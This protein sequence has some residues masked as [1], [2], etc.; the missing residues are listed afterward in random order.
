MQISEAVLD[1]IARSTTDGPRLILPGQ[2]PRPDY[3]AVDKVLKNVGGAWNRG[4][5]AHVFPIDAADAIDSLLAT[6]EIST[7]QEMG[8]FP[9]PLPVVEYLA[10]LADLDPGIEALEPSAGIGAIAE[11]IAP[12]VL[13]VDCYELDPGRADSIRAGGYARTVETADFLTVAPRPVYDR[14]VMNPPF[15]K[16]A[17]VDH[18][19]HALGFVKPGGLLVSV[20]SAGAARREDRKTVEFRKLVADV[21]GWIEDLPEDSFKASGTAV[22]TIVVVIPVGR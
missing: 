5:K 15:A 1:I 22:R 3:V 20:M 21:G 8:Y 10:D 14:V 12:A 16:K 17:D 9:T 4:K 19:L 7:F 11:L 2:L 6:G 18:V 13:A